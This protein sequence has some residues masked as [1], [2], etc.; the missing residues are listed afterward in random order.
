MR[1]LARV[2]Q[3]GIVVGDLEEAANAWIKRGI[4]PFF[5]WNRIDYPTFE[6]RGAPSQPEISLAFSYIGETQLELIHQHNEAPSVYASVRERSGYGLVHLAEY[7]F[8]LTAATSDFRRAGDRVVQYGK[9]REELEIMYFEGGSDGP[10]YLEFI[11]TNEARARRR[12]RMKAAVRA[13]D[14]TR[15]LRFMSDLSDEA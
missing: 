8:D 2:D 12:Q 5:I 6:Y 11:A 3:F 13:W 7:T 14:G 1:S 9:D 15:P 4:G 10:P